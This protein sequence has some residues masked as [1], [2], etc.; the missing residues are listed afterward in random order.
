RHQPS[1]ASSSTRVDR[2]ASPQPEDQH[3][4]IHDSSAT[5]LTLLGGGIQ[6]SQQPDNS[7]RLSAAS[8]TTML[9]P[10]PLSP[11]STNRRQYRA[12][13]GGRLDAMAPETKLR[14]QRLLRQN[15]GVLRQDA[16]SILL[17][18]YSIA[19]GQM[20]NKELDKRFSAVAMEMLREQE[21]RDLHPFGRGGRFE[22]VL[23]SRRKWNAVKNRNNHC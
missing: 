15:A 7:C 1:T 20:S 2:P 22:G 6:A 5:E 4:E 19:P 10:Q 12:A 18:V 3:H 17:G 8:P 21:D 9:K 13:A 14:L 16:T 11:A 23:Y